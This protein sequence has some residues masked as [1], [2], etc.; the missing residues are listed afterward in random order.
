[1]ENK[2]KV[3]RAI[4]NLTQEDL[5]HELDVTRQTINSI[6]KGKYDPSLSLTFK[7]SERFKTPIEDIFSYA[8]DSLK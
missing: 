3:L 4:N 6:E 2:I 8:K 5:T 1:M 7:I